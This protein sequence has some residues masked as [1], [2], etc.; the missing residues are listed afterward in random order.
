M[1]GTLV[2]DSYFC[3]PVSPHVPLVVSDPSKGVL[4]ND[5]NVYG[6]ALS[7]TPTGGT[8]A[9]NPDGTFTWTPTGAGTACAGSFRYYVNGNTAVTQ[10][11]SIVACTT[12]NSCLGGA[13]IANADSYSSNVASRLHVTPP[14]VLANT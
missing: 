10:L 13:P 4:A 11:V 2:P 6:A 14:G 3:L 1:A 8:A 9:L 12:A 7:G 5:R